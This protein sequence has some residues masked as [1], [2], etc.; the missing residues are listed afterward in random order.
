MSPSLGAPILLG[1]V[2]VVSGPVPCPWWESQLE[3]AWS[4]VAAVASLCSRWN[5]SFPPDASPHK[6][7][8]LLECLRVTSQDLKEDYPQSRENRS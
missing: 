5:L 6:G 3:G 4:L 1:P 7:R 8:L 2:P